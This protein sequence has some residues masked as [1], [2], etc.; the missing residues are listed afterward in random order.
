MQIMPKLNS[1]I[2]VLS[3][4]DSTEDLKVFSKFQNQI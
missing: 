2:Y 4:L 3:M 1:V